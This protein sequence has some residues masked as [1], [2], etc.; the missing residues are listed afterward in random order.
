MAELLT[1]GADKVSLNTAALEDPEVITRCADVFGSQCV[2]LAI[3]A[4]KRVDGGGWE[5]FS[6]GGRRAAGRDAVEWAVLGEQ[7]GAG[8]ILLTSMD[9]DGTH[10]GYDIQLLKAVSSAVRLPVIASG[11]AGT[12]DHMYEA[13]TEGGAEATLAASIFHF[14]ELSIAA[15]KQHL[16][17][18]GLEIRAIVPSPRRGKG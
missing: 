8:E 3:D 17:A 15:V 18:R 4:R 7:L 13:L 1:H 5:V 10:A 16:A 2:V 6:H 11:G 14:G 9:Q 12:A